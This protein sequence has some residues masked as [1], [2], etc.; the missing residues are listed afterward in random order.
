VQYLKANK[1]YCIF[2]HTVDGKKPFSAKNPTLRSYQ[3]V[4][5]AYEAGII[6]SYS[7]DIFPCR[8]LPPAVWWRMIVISSSF[9][10]LDVFFQLSFFFFIWRGQCIPAQAKVQTLCCLSGFSK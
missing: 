9:T 8:Q 10:S 7:N 6:T 4:Y 5:F 2:P 3:S 1:F